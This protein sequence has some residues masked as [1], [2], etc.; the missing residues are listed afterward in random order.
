MREPTMDAGQRMAERMR[1]QGLRRI[2]E[3]T[4]VETYHLRESYQVTPVRYH[5]VVG[6]TD[7][8]MYLTVTATALRVSPSTNSTVPNSGGILAKLVISVRKRPT[9][10]SGLTPGSARRSSLTT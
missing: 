10:I 2:R 5:S 9:S 7:A 4:P 8:V 6:G 1:D 3:N